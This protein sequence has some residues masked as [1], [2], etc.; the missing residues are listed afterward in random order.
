MG[1][2]IQKMLES[3]NKNVNNAIRKYGY[4]YGY[5]SIMFEKHID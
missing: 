2:D 3:K 5:L 1:E 4:T